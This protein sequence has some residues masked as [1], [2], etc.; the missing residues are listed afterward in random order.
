LND[1]SGEVTSPSTLNNLLVSRAVA[2]LALP[3]RLAV[4]MLA[5]KLPLASLLTIV[6]GV[7]ELVAFELISMLP[8]FPPL[9]LVMERPTPFTVIALV[10]IS[11]VAL[12]TIIPIVVISDILVR[13]ALRGWPSVIP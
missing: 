11:L 1:T 7:E 5:V 4:I 10:T 2:V 9:P 13:L 8:E 6:S 3:F 12:L